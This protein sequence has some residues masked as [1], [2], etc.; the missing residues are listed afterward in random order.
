ML[1]LSRRRKMFELHRRLIAKVIFWDDFCVS[2]AASFEGFC[3][4]CI[5]DHMCIKY[6]F[7]LL[8][9]KSVYIYFFLPQKTRI[10]NI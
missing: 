4:S 1:S 9:V 5:F 3:R 10:I 7:A 8:H 2:F 6:R